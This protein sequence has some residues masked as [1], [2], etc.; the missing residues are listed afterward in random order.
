LRWN[1]TWSSRSR[2]AQVQTPAAGDPLPSWN[3]GPAK[4][5]ILKFVKATT[6]LKSPDFVPPEDRVAEF[7]QDGTL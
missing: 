3:D 7:D 4:E 1:H 2:P 5:A 6:D